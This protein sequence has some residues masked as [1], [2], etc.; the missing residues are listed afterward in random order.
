V[1]N[2]VVRVSAEFRFY[3]HAAPLG[4]VRVAVGFAEEVWGMALYRD[5]EAWYAGG[6]D[7]S[8]KFDYGPVERIYC[9]PWWEVSLGW[10]YIG[11]RGRIHVGS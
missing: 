4:G 9:C 1:S 10:G 11:E 5:F 6:Q 2:A 8:V 7:C 3:P